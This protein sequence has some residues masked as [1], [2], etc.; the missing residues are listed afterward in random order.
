V[1]RSGKG[2]GGS[3]VGGD[4]EGDR[5]DEA[6]GDEETGVVGMRDERKSRKTSWIC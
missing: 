1:T 2:Y 3:A 5:D 4:G 6:I